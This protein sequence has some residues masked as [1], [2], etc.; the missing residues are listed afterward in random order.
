M[1]GEGTKFVNL[2]LGVISLSQINLRKSMQ[3]I[4]LCVEMPWYGIVGGYFFLL[5][6][7]MGSEK[8]TK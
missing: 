7:L 1:S 3:Y 6:L 4:Q 8:N 2:K 5:N